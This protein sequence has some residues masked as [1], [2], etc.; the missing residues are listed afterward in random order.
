[1][2]LIPFKLSTRINKN[3]IFLNHSKILCQ[4]IFHIIKFYWVK[5]LKSF[6]SNKNDVLCWFGA[7]KRIFFRSNL[8]SDML[9]CKLF[10]WCDIKNSIFGDLFL[11]FIYI[12]MSILIFISSFSFHSCFKWA[13]FFSASVSFKHA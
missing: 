3:F 11:L 9:I 12:F 4:L 1:M 5:A 13:F 8:L 7:Q 6:K 10:H 2:T